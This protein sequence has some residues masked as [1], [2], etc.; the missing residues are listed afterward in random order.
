[1]SWLSNLF[2][3]KYGSANMAR[4]RLRI[5]VAHERYQRKSPDFLP[6]LQEEITSVIAKYVKVEKDQVLVAFGQ[7]GDCSTLELNITLPED[8]PKAK[9]KTPKKKAEQAAAG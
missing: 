5:I 1:M 4:E 2:R 7:K 9:S 8:M 3:P 6:K